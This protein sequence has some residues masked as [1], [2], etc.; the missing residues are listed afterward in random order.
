MLSTNIAFAPSV[1]AAIAEAEKRLRALVERPSD[2][3]IAELENLS[4]SRARRI[5]E[6]VSS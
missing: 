1:E 2:E 3:V 5:M 4:P 6:E